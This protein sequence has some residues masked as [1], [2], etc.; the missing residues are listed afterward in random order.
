MQ[1]AAAIS[2]ERLDAGVRSAAVP[3]HCVIV[4]IGAACIPI[5]VLWDISWHST[6]GRETFWTPAHIMIQL[7]GIVP[8]L[9]C[10]WLAFKTTFYGTDEERAASVKLF[11]AR[12]PLGAWVT[13]WGALAMVT[14]APF[15][16]W[17]HNAYGLDVQIIS[18]PHSLLAVGMFGV[19]LG[20]LLLVL[21]WQNRSEG[22]TRDHI[23][24]LFTL[25][26]GVMVTMNA[27]FVTEESFPNQHHGLVF[28]VVSVLQYLP[29]LA[30]VSRA[31]SQRWPATIAALTYMVILCAMIWALPLFEATPKL[32]PVYRQVTHMVPPA[33]P[34]LLVVPA[35]ALDLIMRW[36]APRMPQA[37]WRL[38][39]PTVREAMGLFRPGWWKEWLLAVALGTAF[40]GL[41]LLV[42]WNF[43]QFLMSNAADNWFFARDGKWPYYIQQGSWMNEFWQRGIKPVTAPGLALVWIVTLLA[44]RFGLW[45]G[46]WM[47]RVCR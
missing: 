8:A 35:F 46:S 14:S 2:T 1:T 15:D 21:A 32:A 47:K 27:V 4:V 25:M 16:D 44:A 18:P 22:K 7:G 43:S 6:I 41:L 26:T 42:Q 37:G 23:G 39:A 31:S 45:Q 30:S 20:C 29:L 38:D 33:F 11:G 36:A 28:Y 19:A 13:I 24:L 9:A 34:L 40:L 12:A 10:G 17:W 5:G 3:W